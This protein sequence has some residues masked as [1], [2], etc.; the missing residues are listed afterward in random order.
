MDCTGDD[1][2]T[3]AAFT[4]HLTLDGLG[5][6]RLMSRFNCRITGTRQPIVQYA[7]HQVHLLQKNGMR[8][9]KRH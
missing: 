2:F 5:A 6:I 9:V 7:V 1:F 3:R 4:N 8:L